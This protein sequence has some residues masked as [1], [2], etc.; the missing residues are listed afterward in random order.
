MDKLTPKQKAF[1]DYYVELGNATEAAI[2]AGYSKKTA[3][4][5]GSENLSK[6]YINQYITERMKKVEEKRIASGDEVLQYLTAV[7]RGEVKDQFELDASL[8]DRTRAAELL[9]K[10]HRLWTEKVEVENKAEEE[11]A[12]KLDNIESILEQMKSVEPNEN[13]KT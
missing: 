1:C 13:E 6:P 2:R 11:K 5:V 3:R 10:R 12:K 9:G 4:Q 7:M 8:Q